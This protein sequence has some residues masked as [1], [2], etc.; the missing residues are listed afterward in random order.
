MKVGANMFMNVVMMCAHLFCSHFP[1]NVGCVG[2]F[3]VTYAVVQC[4]C[5]C[6]CVC[7]Y[8]S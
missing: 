1:V 6:V 8:V 2:I 7:V 4:V 5:V 3:E